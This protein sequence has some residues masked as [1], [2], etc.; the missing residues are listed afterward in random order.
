M[1]LQH[2]KAIS[3]A[4]CSVIV[5]G[6][7]VGELYLHY[8]N[9]YNLLVVRL[10]SKFDLRRLCR[11]IGATALPRVVRTDIT[12]FGIYQLAYIHQL[13]MTFVVISRRPPPLTR[14]VTVTMSMW[15]R[16]E[17]RPSSSSNRVSLCSHCVWKIHGN[18][19]YESQK[20]QRIVSK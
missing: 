1:S 7:K 10:M 5:S 15:T 13:I 3:D 2:I 19:F 11:A 18:E 6:V 4:G 14:P 9:K 8:C 20:S 12:L 16:S 17:T